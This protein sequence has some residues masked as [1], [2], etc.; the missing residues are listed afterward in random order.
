MDGA[1]AR[2]DSLW[3]G[4]VA[5]ASFGLGWM[6]RKFVHPN[7]DDDDDWEDIDTEDES[8]DEDLDT[9][10]ALPV[11][12]RAPGDGGAA[13][14]LRYPGEECK[15]VLLVRMDLKMQKGKVAAQC[16]HATLACYKAA[17]KFQNKVLQRWEGLGQAKIALKVPDDVELEAIMQQARSEGLIAMPIRDAG[18]TQ[19]AAGSRTV[20]GI[21]PAPKSAI[22]KFCKHLK[23]L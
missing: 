21:G 6:A 2:S 18:R 5:A 23:L 10:M 4:A 1:Q 9:S 19:I 22:D 8:E 17:R 20:L 13:L 14:L 15:M 7:E 11:S 12:T 3:S 16:G